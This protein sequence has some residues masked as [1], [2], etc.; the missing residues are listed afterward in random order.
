MPDRTKLFLT[1]VAQTFRGAVPLLLDS[2]AGAVIDQR[3]LPA[4]DDGSRSV[5]LDDEA[6]IGHDW[7]DPCWE[8]F[9][10]S[11]PAPAA[12]PPPRFHT[13]ACRQQFLAAQLSAPAPNPVSD[14][15]L[16]P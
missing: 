4:A 5:R 2:E 9:R 1:H 13:A 15:T 6:I 3:G 11:A 16:K 12:A 10:R 14:S 8:A 7:E